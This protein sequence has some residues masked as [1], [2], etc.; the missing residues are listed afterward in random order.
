MLH[1]SLAFGQN[2]LPYRYSGAC[3]RYINM[4]AWISGRALP[5]WDEMRPSSWAVKGEN[6]KMSRKPRKSQGKKAGKVHEKL[7]KNQ[8]KVR[9]NRKSSGKQDGKSEEG[10]GGEGKS[11][12]K[13]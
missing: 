6:R 13:K 10:G 4:V 11:Q 2:S 12:R 7:G 5:L 8:E 9:K 3:G 1:I